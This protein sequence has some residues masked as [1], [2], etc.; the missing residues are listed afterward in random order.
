MPLTHELVRLFRH[1]GYLKLDECLPAA[2]VES[3]KDKIQRDLSDEVEPVVRN[4]EGRTVRISN[5]LD[6]GPL[7]KETASHA[8]LLDIL[9]G[10][11]GPRIEI[12][13]NRHNHATLNL[14]T[15]QD[16]S[17][18][19]DSVQW[20]RGLV[21]VIFFLGRITFKERLYPDSSRDASVARH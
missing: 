18:H 2:M 5:I 21:S 7:F 4:K 3:L 19:R 20:S 16:A 10:L 13:K 15:G 6:R 14:A 11:L 9:E 17:F 1:N 12:V 8:P